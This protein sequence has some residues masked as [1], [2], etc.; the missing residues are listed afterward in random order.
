MAK[1]EISNL[2]L[3]IKLTL[4]CLNNGGYAKIPSIGLRQDLQEVKRGPDGKADPDTISTRVNAFML[5]ILADHT[6]PPFYHPEYI[7]EYISTLQK[8]LSFEQTNIDT[9]EQFDEVYDEFKA[10]TDMLFRGQ[11]EAKWRLYSNL[12]RNWMLKRMFEAENSYPELLVNLVENGRAEYSDQIR[13]L[14][15]AHHIDSVNDISVLGYLQH[16]G[17]PT[18]L[19]DWTYRFQNALFFA[20]D[21]VT[22][23][24]GTIEIEDYLSVYYIDENHFRESNMR[25]FIVEGLKVIGEELKNKEIERIAKNKAKAAAMKKHF[26]DRNFFDLQRIA[27]SGLI[28]HMTRIKSLMGFP[29]SYFSDKDIDSGILFSLNNSKNIQNQV[30]V[31]T[32]NADPSKPLEMVGDEL[33]QEVK[34]EDVDNNYFFCSCFNIHKNLVNHVRSRLEA[35][36]IT[37]DFIYP[38]PDINTWEV[39]EKSKRK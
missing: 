22:Q 14:L 28:A 31:F 3:K 30:G 8:S 29:I 24:P 6:T 1:R 7:T 2:D 13:E 11:R 12:Q 37:R 18:P 5:A 26:A 35:D 25:E 32:W 39:F 33:Y 9:V 19:L 34:P 15:S 16:H 27:G 10:K 21:G 4:E 36:G 17:C 20:L 23:N 38:T